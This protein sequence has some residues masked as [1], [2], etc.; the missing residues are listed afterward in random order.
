MAML[1]RRRDT[2]EELM[3]PGRWEP[4]RLLR[5]FLGYDPFREMER[6]AFQPGVVGFSPDMEVRETKDSFFFRAD[7]PGVKEED[8]D[9]SATGNRLTISGRREADTPEE[10]ESY[11]CCER[12]YGSFT[13]SFTLPEGIDLDDTKAELRDGILTV[14]V[15]KK[16]EVQARKIAIKGGGGGG[17]T[18]Q[19]KA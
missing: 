7:L 8:L 5:E 15:P 16:P 1:I 12:P 10:S 14:V 2:G 13:R 18:K 19:V 9:I 4:F 17:P 11:Y 6:A 3:P